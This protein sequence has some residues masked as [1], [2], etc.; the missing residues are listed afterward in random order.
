MALL[1]KTILDGSTFRL[2]LADG[3]Q[4]RVDYVDSAGATQTETIDESDGEAAY[5]P[6][7]GA[8]TYHLARR[9]SAT[10]DWYRIGALVV[11]ALV[12]EEDGRLVAE[13]GGGQRRSSPT[14]T[15][16]LVQYQHTDPSGTAVMRMKLSEL[17]TLR[18]RLEIRLTN[19]RRKRQGRY[20]LRFA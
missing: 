8:R 2:A 18:A 6:S 11:E 15:A 3:E 19:Y 12:D 16:E 7:A 9:E 1:R 5:Q 13:L 10:A 4:L 20:P 14:N 17:N